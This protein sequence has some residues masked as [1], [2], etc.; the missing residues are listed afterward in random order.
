MKMGIGFW[1]ITLGFDAYWTLAIIWREQ[2]MPFLLPGAVL[3]L[4]LT[5]PRQR[6]W[7]LSA[8]LL[9]ITMDALWCYL[10]IFKFTGQ[11]GVPLWM[12]A[13][14]LTFSSWLYWLLRR[15]RPN[16]KTVVLLGAVAGPLA[17]IIGWKLNAMTPQIAPEIMILTLSLGWAIYLPV[18]S[19]PILRRRIE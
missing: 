6:I 1:L 10:Y 19:W 13:L 11:T 2:A 3:A 14:W 5:P 7:V 17:Y 18:V 12:W 8:A 4:I 16:V 9:G 15:I